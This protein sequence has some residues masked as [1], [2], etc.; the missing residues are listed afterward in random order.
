[1]DK[2]TTRIS[3]EEFVERFVIHMKKLLPSKQPLEVDGQTF[4]EYAKEIAKEYYADWVHGNLGCET[5]EECAE[6]D[7]S[8]LGE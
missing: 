2:E 7:I 8:Y 1:M 3:E 4:E 5:P 6:A